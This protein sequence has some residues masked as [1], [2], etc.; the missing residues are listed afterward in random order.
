MNVE[1]SAMKFILYGVY[2][3]KLSSYPAVVKDFHKSSK[4][5]LMTI[6]YIQKKYRWDWAVF[7]VFGQENFCLY[8]E[9][10]RYGT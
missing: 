6:V 3:E 1:K 4:I 2:G 10:Y 9:N 7:Q 8:S 5:V